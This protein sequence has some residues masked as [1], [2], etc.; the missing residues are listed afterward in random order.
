MRMNRASV[1]AAAGRRI[2]A[3]AAVA[4]T[5][6]LATACGSSGARPAGDGAPTASI[7]LATSDGGA[8][9]PGWAVVE[10]GG[11]SASFN[12][13]WE[14]FVRPPGSA[15]WKL[16]TPLGVASNG[17]LAITSTGPG[18]VAGFQPSQDLTF[19]PLATAASSAAAWSQ[20]GAPVSPGLASVPDALAAG[21]AGQVLALTDTGEVL[22]GARQGSTWTRLAT[23][24]SIAGSAAGRACGLTALT[25][26]AF[27]PAGS[28]LAGGACTRPGSSGIFLLGQGSPAAVALSLSGGPVTVLGLAREAAGRTMALLNVGGGRASTIVAAWLATTAPASGTVSAAAPTGG[29]VPRSLAMW[30][31]GSAGLVLAGGRAETIAGPGGS[32][33]A[34]PALPAKAAT[35][36][37]G[38]AGQLEAIVAQGNSF[39]V[40][41]LSAAGTAWAPVQHISVAIPYGSSD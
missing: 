16:A 10:M 8:G 40:W 21:P 3:V 35:L 41:Q 19:S 12:N 1:T 31:N 2:T 4:L 29:G 22:L 25:A 17:G 24:R 11:S 20:A 18:L 39:N 30:S 38:P 5:A 23:L 6:G 32:W 14:L 34:L 9:L 7:P 15:Q 13:F 33:H 26:V 28:P 37:L 36:A 27:T